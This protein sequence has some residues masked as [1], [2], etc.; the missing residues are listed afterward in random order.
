MKE[1]MTAAHVAICPAEVKQPSM[2]IIS[3]RAF[4]KIQG[5]CKCK[6]NVMVCSRDPSNEV[7]YVLATLSKL[8]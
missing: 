6:V 5:R 7:E 2:T 3:T 4:L 1:Q 8:K